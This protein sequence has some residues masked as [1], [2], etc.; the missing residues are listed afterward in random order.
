MTEPS[1]PTGG[2]DPEDEAIDLPGDEE[3]IEIE[4]GEPAASSSKIRAFGGPARHGEHWDRTPNVTGHGAIHCKVFHAKLREDA[5]DYM[6]RQIN[7]WL[8][9]HPEY[10]VKQ[11]TSSIG[12]MKTKTISEAALIVTV[13]V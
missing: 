1:N 4:G 6:E 7:E 8:D 13:W 5:I 11:V 9:A 2:T 3:A 10:E 12:E